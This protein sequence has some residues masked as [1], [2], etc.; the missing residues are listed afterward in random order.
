MFDP[1]ATWANTTAMRLRSKATWLAVLGT[2][3]APPP[4]KVGV[5]ENG[6][7]DADGFGKIVIDQCG[8]FGAGGH[9]AEPGVDNQRS[10]AAAPNGLHQARGGIAVHNVEEREVQRLE[11]SGES[12]IG[13]VGHSEVCR[14]TEK[15]VVLWRQPDAGSATADSLDDGSGHLDGEARVVL[16]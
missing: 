14:Q 1:S 4:G 3:V 16:R 9:R 15:D 10:P 13:L 7:A 12:E 5:R 2:T 6:A 8:T 11:V